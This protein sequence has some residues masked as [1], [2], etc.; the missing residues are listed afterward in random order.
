MDSPDP[1]E[2]PRT[3]LNLGYAIP[4]ADKTTRKSKGKKKARRK[5]ILA[6]PADARPE[7]ADSWFA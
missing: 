5:A 4:E 2:D 3:G 6:T 7:E 1:A